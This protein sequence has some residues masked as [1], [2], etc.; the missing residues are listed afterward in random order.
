M[1]AS[2]TSSSGSALPQPFQTDSS[3]SPRIEEGRQYRAALE[4]MEGLTVARD[5]ETAQTE[6]GE[7]RVSPLLPP[8]PFGRKAKPPLTT[9]LTVARTDISFS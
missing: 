8:P 2:A 5:A 1:T 9:R 3:I 4:G 7:P 6:A